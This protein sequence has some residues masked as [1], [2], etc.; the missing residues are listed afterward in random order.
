MLI[1]GAVGLGLLGP[2]VALVI[3]AVPPILAGTYAGVRNVDS[4]VVDAARGMGMREREIL[5][6][7]ELP[8]ALPL[9]I[10]GIRSSVLQVISTATIAAYVALGGLGR[11]IID[12]LAVRDYPMMVAGSLLVALLAIVGDLLLAGQQKLL[13]SPGLRAAPAASRR[14]RL[15]PARTS[16]TGNPGA[17]PAA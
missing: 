4:S 2:I 6:G 5:F 13:V 3:L 11:F 10:G 15:V 12:G 8:N 16:D 1:G 9:I 17:A 7:V 14:L